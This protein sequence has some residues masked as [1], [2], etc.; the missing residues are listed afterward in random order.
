VALALLK[1]HFLG[2]KNRLLGR[3]RGAKFFRR[4]WL[5]LL[6][7]LLICL[8]IYQSLF[9]FL[10]ASKLED[11]IP[12]DLPG[13]LISLYLFSFFL[14]LLFSNFISALGFFFFAKDLPL[15][16]T[17]P[18]SRLEFYLSRV[19]ITC[20]HASWIFF[21][22][23]IPLV[24]AYHAAFNLPWHFILV[25]ALVSLPVVLI[26]AALGSILVNLFVNLLPIDRMQELLMIATVALLFLASWV[27]QQLPAD[28]GPDHRVQEVASIV[29]QMDDPHPIW[30]PTRAASEILNSY[31]GYSTENPWKMGGQLTLWLV[32]SFGLGLLVFSKLFMRGWTRSL[33]GRRNL[34]IGPSP[35]FDSV[36]H[37]LLPFNPQLRALLLKDMRMFL[38]DTTQLM[39]LVLL[40][41]LTFVYLYNFKGLRAASALGAEVYSWWQTILVIANIALGG[42]VVAALATRFVYPA[43]SLEGQAY[44]IVRSAPMSIR[45]LLHDKFLIWILPVTLVSLGL[46]TAGAL[47]IQVPPITVFLCAAL[48]VAL[49]VGIV[50]LAIGVGAVYATFDWETTAQLTANFGSLIFMMLSLGLVLVT[51]IPTSLLIMLNNIPGI[52]EKLDRIDYLVAMCSA[53]FLVFFINFAT[54]RWAM[55][56]GAE[57]LRR[58]EI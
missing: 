41:I 7:I 55:N 17:A 34:R 35:I 33:K 28:L 31:L 26:P 38:R 16:L 1:P 29:N 12:K 9:T 3:D 42:C 32:G 44:W 24:L 20:A 2:Y 58:R 19:L 50:G 39:Q 8:A 52:T 56:V 47:V 54:A 49:S 5:V 48:A 37:W 18:I 27:P 25:A 10:I 43:I 46:L 4:E 11:R 23:G 21:L 6:F 13:K 57:A 53:S 45:Q 14:L 51:I 30:S 22:F 40:L 36:A 15:I